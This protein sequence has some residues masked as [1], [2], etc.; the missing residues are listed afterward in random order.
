MDAAVQ[1]VSCARTRIGYFFDRYYVDLDPQ[2]V[3]T[4][5]SPDVWRSFLFPVYANSRTRWYYIYFCYA[6][7]LRSYESNSP[8][9]DLHFAFFKERRISN[10]GY[11]A[12]ICYSFPVSNDSSL[13]Y[14]T[15][16]G[17]SKRGCLRWY[18]YRTSI[19]TDNY[20]LN[21]FQNASPFIRYRQVFGSLRN[22]LFRSIG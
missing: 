16:F 20:T 13:V 15:I 19:F 12:G 7:Y 18:N 10:T 14:F 6:S 21:T 8:N 17:T 5:D 11:Y 2:M 1:Q 3:W 4:T 22:F 9:Q